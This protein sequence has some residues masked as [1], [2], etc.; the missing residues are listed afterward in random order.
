MDL[1]V[2][3]L[4]RARWSS[5]IHE[6]WIRG[7]K[8]DRPDIPEENLRRTQAFMD[9]NVRDAL[10]TDYESLVPS[11]SLPDPD[12]LHVLAAAIRC[13]ASVIVTFNLKDFPPTALS[14]WGIEAQHPDVFLSNLI[15]LHNIPVLLAVEK[16]RQRFKKPPIHF[17]EYLET[18]SRLKLSQFSAILRS[19]YYS[20]RF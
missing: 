13:S 14:P 2:T 16:S 11:L 12:D 8:K 20:E 1:A 4:Y 15:D 5:Q 10:V 17:E 6:E 19:I 7:L 3:D 9:K 18:L